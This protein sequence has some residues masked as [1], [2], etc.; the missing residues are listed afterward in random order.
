MIKNDHLKEIVA[1]S[2]AGIMQTLVG[3]PFD[4]VKVRYINSDTKSIRSCIQMMIRDNGVR[5]F[6][7]GIKSPLY[8]GVFYN[9]NM[10]LSYRLFDNYLSSGTS[11]IFYDS[12]ICGSLVGVTTTF[13]ECPIDLVK[14]QMQIDK[15]LTFR[16]MI[17][18]TN[19]KT[20]YRGFTPTIIRNIPASG[21][22]FGVYNYVYNYYKSNNQ[23][24]L[25]S[26]VA[27]GSAGAIC[28][29]STYPLDNIKT[30]IQSDGLTNRKYKNMLDCIRKTSFRNM[31]NGFIPC[32]VRAVPVNAAIFF[33]YEYA[34]QTMDYN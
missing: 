5:S 33:G 7:Q 10:F 23:P 1:G 17:M 22:Y 15:R 28:W 20:L 25:G 31:W 4:T 24:L 16:G 9:T 30:R 21:F 2:A 34:K 8:G 32:I 26:L 13:F 14:T 11:S 6:Y 3:Y 27:G 12:F 19:I 18:G 29:S